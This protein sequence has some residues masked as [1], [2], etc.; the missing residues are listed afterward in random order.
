[1]QAQP[2]LSWLGKGSRRL[3]PPGMWQRP[4]CPASKLAGNEMQSLL[5]QAK[6]LANFELAW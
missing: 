5:K 1:M 4:R 3:E 2:T 6:A